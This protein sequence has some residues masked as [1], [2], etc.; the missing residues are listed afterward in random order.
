MAYMLTVVV[1][2]DAAHHLPNHKGACARVHGH[3]WR[4]EV[5]WVFDTLGDD[6]MANDFADLKAQVRA[7]LPDHR[8]LNDVYAFVPTAENLARH[9]CETLQAYT[10]RVWESEGSCASYTAG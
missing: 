1:T 6:G 7:A 3:T 8:D 2:F 5:D 9:F 10:V 4:V